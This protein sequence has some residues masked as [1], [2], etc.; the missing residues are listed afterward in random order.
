MRSTIQLFSAVLL[1]LKHEVGSIRNPNH[2]L[3]NTAT[4]PYPNNST[5]VQQTQTPST[6]TQPRRTTQKEAGTDSLTIC[7]LS[8]LTSSLY[9][10]QRGSSQTYWFDVDTSL[11]LQLQ[12]W[13]HLPMLQGWTEEFLPRFLLRIGKGSKWK[14]KSRISTNLS[15]FTVSFCLT[16]FPKYKYVIY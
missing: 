2:Q 3:R 10:L 5:K 7:L 15:K 6:K 9:K 4:Q 11:L 12:L 1:Y 8:P 14:I 13:Q 16:K